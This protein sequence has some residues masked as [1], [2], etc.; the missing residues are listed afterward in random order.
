M[1][2]SRLTLVFIIFLIAFFVLF[3]RLFKLTIV[4]GETYREFSD[5]N[6]IKEINLDASRGLI[7]DRDGNE[8]ASN[9]LIY[10]LNVFSDRFNRIEEDRK[11]EILLSLVEILEED[12]VDYLDNNFLSIYEYTYK[13][14]DDYFNSEELPRQK[15]INIIKENNLLGE[16]LTRKFDIDNG[17]QFYPVKRIKDYLIL[18]GKSIPVSV[19][20]NDGL[21]LDFID[22]EEFNQ[23]IEND[24]ISSSSS[25]LQYILDQIADD[26]SYISYLI[27]H[28]LVRKITFDIIEEKNLA[29][30]LDISDLIF[31]N[32]LQ[33]LENKVI[34][35][36]YSDEVTLS[37]N[38]KDDFLALVK[39]NALETLL[40]NAYTSDDRLI[41]PASILISELER[42]GIET[43]LD[44][45]VNED[46]GSVD[47]IYKDENQNESHLLAPERLINLA[48]ENNILDE[49]ILSENILNYSERAL[50]DNGIYP[51]IYKDTWEYS[52]I[53]DKQDALAS[54]EDSETI[55]PKAYFDTLREDYDL[56]DANEYLSY[57]AISIMEVIEK[58]GY[59]GYRPTKIA[60]NINQESLIKIE[61]SIP[62]DGGFE[63]IFQPNRYYPN[64]NTG[65]HILGYLGNISGEQ[66]VEHYLGLKEY[67]LNDIVGKTGIEQSFEDT[68]R[69]SKGSQLVYTNVYGQTTEI[70]E[71]TDAIPG[72]NLYTT[73]DI[74]FQKEVEDILV[75]TMYSI[76]TGT[77]YESYLGT[78]TEIT[79]SSG[80]EIA[81]A[82]VM[83]VTNGEI[84]AMVSLPDYNPNLFVNGISS[85]D[86]NRLNNTNPDDI[87][88]P[89][90]I[91]NNVVQS[92]FTPGSTFKTV[93]S[94]AALEKGLNPEDPIENHGYVEIG[95]QRFNDLIYTTTGQA[96]GNLNLYDAL[97]VS[98]NYYFY[99]LGLG[100]NPNKPGDNDIKVTL[101]DIES[102]TA[103]LG[104]QSPTGVEI[105]SPVESSGYHPNLSGKT[106]ILKAELRRYLETNLADYSKDGMEIAET[107]LQNDI[108]EIVR[109]VDDGADMSYEQVVD[110]IS[111]MGYE[112]TEALEGQ[113]EGIASYIKF[114][115][116][117]MAQWTD[118]DSMNM[119]IGQGQNA[120]TPLQMVQLAGILANDGTL[121]KP[122]LVKKI[123]NHDN[124]EVLFT[125]K[126]AFKETGV[127]PEYF[128]AVKEGMRRASTTSALR[129]K[130]PFEIASKSGTAEVGSI[131]PDT[132]EVYEPIVSEIT[133]A[134]MNNPEIA[135]FA[136]I[137]EGSASNN[138]RLAVTDIYYA[139]Y[140]YVKNDPS[141]TASRPGS[142]LDDPAEN[143]SETT[144]EVAE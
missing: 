43:G 10:N 60:N 124:T 52:Y 58:Q 80:A 27:A 15:V 69:G 44:Y 119:V 141:Y 9:K 138:V 93:T 1:K 142:I 144:E 35:N 25:P 78:E 16:I 102:M 139:Y 41:V 86:W 109:W 95:N 83:D 111:N 97:K 32:D 107:K 40:T 118:G 77:P 96:W 113:R 19:D 87:F 106:A 123:E 117:N 34:L 30:N 108:D 48:N 89:R 100:Y 116:L 114:S 126:P 6:R 131:N 104:L 101:T 39:E 54:F 51:R 130:L 46:L 67:D 29:D 57:G 2:K 63:I 49:F 105:N 47:I 11:S 110:S 112:A 88:A 79:Q 37:S 73:I 20:T 120:Y 82:V 61:E 7:F 22:N 133:F 68:L 18:R 134:P 24:L 85:F 127:N 66:E 76:R 31:I 45:T 143:I 36:N 135:V 132:G 26:E 74:D 56:L 64:G 17:V 140:K 42:K 14:E 136:N 50:F 5:N 13:N 53:S 99:V 125:Q 70:I 129:T 38:A 12:G 90:P 55:S 28:P 94:L 84:L 71:Q 75:D 23:L 128:A 122:T 115:Y 137:V 4:D 81:T 98:S 121:V 59:M 8:L 72:N 21:K 91:L 62:K 65:S 103:R 33:Q 3:A 92:A